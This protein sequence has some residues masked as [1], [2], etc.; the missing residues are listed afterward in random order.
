MKRITKGMKVYMWDYYNSSV[1]VSVVQPH[2]EIIGEV[3]NDGDT[4]RIKSIMDGNIYTAQT[5]HVFEVGTGPI[6]NIVYADENNE[7]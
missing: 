3:L 7:C 5:S 2:E 4:I 1:T 6:K